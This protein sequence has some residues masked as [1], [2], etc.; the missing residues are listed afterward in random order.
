MIFSFLSVKIQKKS[1]QDASD[2]RKT[3]E[4]HQFEG[5]SQKVFR[6]HWK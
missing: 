3:T 6:K 2:G 4:E 5:Q 1:L